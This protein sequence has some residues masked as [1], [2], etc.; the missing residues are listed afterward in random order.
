MTSSDFETD[1]TDQAMPLDPDPAVPGVDTYTPGV[2]AGS[3]TPSGE[4][5]LVDGVEGLD[6][7]ADADAV[8][9][10]V[11]PA[12]AADEATTED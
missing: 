8:E 4:S 11:I 7:N 3:D 5:D 10:Q 2:P 12:G 9:T 1:R 6:S